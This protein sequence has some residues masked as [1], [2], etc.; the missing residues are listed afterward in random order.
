MDI[1]SGQGVNQLNKYTPDQLVDLWQERSTASDFEQ[2][3][4]DFEQDGYSA[5]QSSR[6][7]IRSDK[8]RNNAGK[9]RNAMNGSDESE[10]HAHIASSIANRS[11]TF[12]DQ[13]VHTHNF[14]LVQQYRSMRY[15]FL[16]LAVGGA[17]GG[18]M[19]TALL[20]IDEQYLGVLVKPF[21]LLSSAPQYALILQFILLVAMSVGLSAASPGVYVF[22]EE[23]E[24]Y[25]RNASSGHNRL[26]YFL[27]KNLSTIYR[28]FLASLHFAS[29][30][31]FL[32]AI[33]IPFPI[34]YVIILGMYFGVYGLCHTVSMITK[35]E[36]ATLL[37]LVLSLFSSAF[38]GY[39]IHITDAKDWHLYPIWLLQFNMWGSEAFFSSVL[40]I[41]DHV[42][43]SDISNA[44]FGYTLN[45]IPTDF[46][47]MFIIGF[48]WRVIAYFC[49]IYFNRDKQ[50]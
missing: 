14:S 39:G 41:Y 29:V 47:A 3:D 13:L 30:L 31:Y 19:G 23:I 33:V 42:Y 40:S 5:D 38:C 21:S 27:G 4:D 8:V 28:I 24:V 18:V 7:S 45:R 25:W 48:G 35:R 10:F 9:R 26:A 6:E 50:R 32:G 22:S 36:S 49:M 43:D 11:A 44:V 34:L 12:W 17:A 1:L 2:E 16:E 46:V 15:L 20:S 37:A